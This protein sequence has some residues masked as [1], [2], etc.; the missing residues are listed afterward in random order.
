MSS[1]KLSTF[2]G[3]NIHALNLYPGKKDSKDI[4]VYLT[5]D[6]LDDTEWIKNGLPE[7]R[8]TINGRDCSKK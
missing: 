2:Y 1:Q 8:T 4:R 6:V 7:L 3:S 5:L